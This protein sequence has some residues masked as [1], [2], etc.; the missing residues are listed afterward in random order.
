M[1]SQMPLH[2]CKLV[3]LTLVA[4][5]GAGRVASCRAAEPQVAFAV[6]T[7]WL[8]FTLRQ[9]G[10][11]VPDATVLVFDEDGRQFAEGETGDQGRGQFPLPRGQAFHVEIK[12]G[13][14]TADPIRLRRSGDGK[15]V[16]PANVLLSFGLRPCCRVVPRSERVEAQEPAPAPFASPL[17]VWLQGAVGMSFL[18]L[19]TAV[20]VLARGG[21]PAHPNPARLTDE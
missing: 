1:E 9:N 18:L 3:T 21:K 15:S 2:P 14:R 11:P 6:K 7:G 12:L 20:L 10:E 17:P 4:L 8:E 5:L 16:V 13:G 19:G